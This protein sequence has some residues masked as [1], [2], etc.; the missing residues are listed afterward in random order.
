[1]FLVNLTLCLES[2]LGIFGFRIKPSI[3][4]FKGNLKSHIYEIKQK[5]TKL[6]FFNLLKDKFSCF[7]FNFKNII[8]SIDRC[9]K[10]SATCKSKDMEKRCIWKSG[11]HSKHHNNETTSLQELRL[12]NSLCFFFQQTTLIFLS[13]SPSCHKIDYARLA[14]SRSIHS[15]A[16]FFLQTFVKEVLRRRSCSSRFIKL[17]RHRRNRN[18]LEFGI[19]LEV[20]YTICYHYE[21]DW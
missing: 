3:V 6:L 15:D 11:V 16:M 7:C 21:G 1:M 14:L 20:R 17:S 10:I 18:G 19:V 13:K 12:F 8:D 5:I 2:V 9:S 4:L